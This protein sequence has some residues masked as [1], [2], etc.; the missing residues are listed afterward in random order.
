MALKIEDWTNKKNKFE[1]ALF[2][3]KDCELEIPLE[4]NIKSKEPEQNEKSK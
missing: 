2:K 1:Y 4:N 3:E